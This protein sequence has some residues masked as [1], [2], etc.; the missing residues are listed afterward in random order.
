MIK[1]DIIHNTVDIK[2]LEND[3]SVELLSRLSINWSFINGLQ[4]HF[5]FEIFSLKGLV[6]YLLFVYIH[7]SEVFQITFKIC[8]NIASEILTFKEH[9]IQII[10]AQV[11]TVTHIQIYQDCSVF[12]LTW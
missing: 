6:N 5:S 4:I 12:P 8:L 9:S 3:R 1:A 7:I 10:K 11:L 2:Y